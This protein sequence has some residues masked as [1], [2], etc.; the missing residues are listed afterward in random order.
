MQAETMHVQPKAED[1]RQ[2]YNAVKV[3]VG[4]YM[5]QL[6]CLKSILYRKRPGYQLR[7]RNITPQNGHGRLSAKADTLHHFVCRMHMDL[8]QWQLRR[9]ILTPQLSDIA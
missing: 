5:L 1:R 3:H 2:A 9:A 8:S 7:L 4:S 6:C